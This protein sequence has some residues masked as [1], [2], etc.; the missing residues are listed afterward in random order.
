MATH[1]RP[2]TSAQP[3]ADTCAAIADGLASDEA[4]KHLAPLWES[5][6]AKGDALAAE[7]R[8]LERSLG[9]ARARLAVADAQ[10][11]PEVAAFG[12]DVVDKTGGRRDAAPYT[13]FFKDVSP[14]AAQDFGVDREV[15]QGR[16][17]TDELGRNPD[18]PL[19]L[20]WSPRLGAVTDKL[21]GA[22]KERANGLRALALQG[23]SEE[24]YVEDIN[25]ELDRLE[26]DLKKL[27]PG[28]PKRVAAFLEPTRARRKRAAGD[29]DD[30]ESGDGS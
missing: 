18:E 16:E 2:N 4:T 11:D 26:G 10:W 3:A 24:L 15:K 19:A 28:Q 29:G 7:R 30:A 1:L 20:K 25:L 23:T 9:R 21:D 6:T 27:F 17:W 5:L 14:S 22:A 8:K 12:R 13:R